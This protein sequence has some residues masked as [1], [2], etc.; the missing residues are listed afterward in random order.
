M[1]KSHLLSLIFTIGLIA[2]NCQYLKPKIT[3]TTFIDI[4]IDGIPAGRIEFGLYGDVAPKT[5]E[6]FRVFCTGERGPEFHYKGT[7]IH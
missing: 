1:I 6:N 4:S 2:V 7:P 3:K 5:V